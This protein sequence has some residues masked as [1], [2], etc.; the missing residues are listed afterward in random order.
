MAAADSAKLPEAPHPAAVILRESKGKDD[1]KTVEVAEKQ[2]LPD[3]Q[4]IKK[5]KAE[6]ELRKSI[7]KNVENRKSLHHVEPQE[8]VVLPSSDDVKREKSETALREEIES[9]DKHL[10][11]VET[12]EKN[13]LP[14]KKTIEEEKKGK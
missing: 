1:L 13:I 12:K 10:S 4:T 5:E 9:K 2:V 3:S 11:H 14:D 6:L 8:K 7:E